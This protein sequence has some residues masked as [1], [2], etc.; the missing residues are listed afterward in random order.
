MIF[1]LAPLVSFLVG[2]VACEV[3]ARLIRKGDDL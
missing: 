1:L 2:Y 3:A